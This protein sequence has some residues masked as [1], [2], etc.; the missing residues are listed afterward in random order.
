[1]A[2]FELYKLSKRK[3]IAACQSLKNNLEDNI[4]LAEEDRFNGCAMRSNNVAYISELYGYLVEAA[5]ELKDEGKL[6]G[7]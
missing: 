3:F 4:R 6:D 1:M 7:V 5:Q 2:N